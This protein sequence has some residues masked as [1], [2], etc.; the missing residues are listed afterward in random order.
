M[1]LPMS[2]RGAKNVKYTRLP[3][4]HRVIPS[5]G[6]RDT[7]PDLPRKLGVG[8]VNSLMTFVTSSDPPQ[9]FI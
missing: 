4:P 7:Y 5:K 6:E 8:V 1:C 3:L 9:T 2:T